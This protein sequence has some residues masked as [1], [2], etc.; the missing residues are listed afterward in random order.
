MLLP[1][2]SLSCETNLTYR[3]QKATTC[4]KFT[5]FSVRWFSLLNATPGFVCSWEIVA[6]RGYLSL[7]AI[8]QRFSHNISK[9]KKLAIDGFKYL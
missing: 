3:F 2:I 8:A 9:W 7:A 1:K 4:N 6:D 5:T